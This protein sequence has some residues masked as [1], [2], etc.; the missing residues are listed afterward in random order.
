MLKFAD[1]SNDGGQTWPSL[2]TIADSGR[3]K[4]SGCAKSSKTS[5]VVA[6][7]DNTAKGL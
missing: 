6:P 2:V 3:A 4:E 1:C 5:L 7:Q